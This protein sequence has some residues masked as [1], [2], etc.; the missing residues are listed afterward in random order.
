MTALVGM[1]NDDLGT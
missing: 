1:C